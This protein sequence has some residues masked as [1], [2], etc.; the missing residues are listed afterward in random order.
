MMPFQ[1]NSAGAAERRAGGNNGVAG[2]RVDELSPE[3]V[4]LRNDVQSMYSWMS[5]SGYYKRWESYPGFKYKFAD[6]VVRNGSEPPV[7]KMAEW[8]LLYKMDSSLLSLPGR[9]GGTGINRAN[10]IRSFETAILNRSTA[11]GMTLTP[12]VISYIAKVA[13]AQDFSSEQLMNAIVDLVDFESVKTGEL[14]S[15]LDDMKAL[16]RSYLIATSDETLQDYAKKLATGAATVDGIES[17][18]RAQAK[19]LFPWMASTIDAGVS[20]EEMLRPARDMIA[21]SLGL[22]NTEV[23]FTNDRFIKLATFEDEKQ[24]TRLATQQEL[25]KNIRSDEAWA[26]TSEARTTATGMASMLSRI[27]GRSAY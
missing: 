8:G 3:L 27:F 22:A 5:S 23:D 26:N 18:F 21:K 16:G 13:E 4:N 17:A 10:T 19:A 20:P 24:G 12:E 2:P 25:M 14:T 1:S 7:W 9:G 11:L 15:S 6:W